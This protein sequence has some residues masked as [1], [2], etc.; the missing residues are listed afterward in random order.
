MKTERFDKKVMS[1]LQQEFTKFG[2]EIAKKF[3]LGIMANNGSYDERQA[4]FCLKFFTKRKLTQPI[5]ERR[6]V[7]QLLE[8]PRIGERFYSPKLKEEFEIVGYNKDDIN[9]PIIC[10]GL[11]TK[12]KLAFPALIK[13]RIGTKPPKRKVKHV[14]E[15]VVNTKPRK[16]VVDSSWQ[17]LVHKGL[18]MK[19]VYIGQIMSHGKPYSKYKTEQGKFIHQIVR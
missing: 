1:Q 11:K 4:N 5:T 12:K 13:N 16:V 17:E 7:A 8:Y 2:S 3:G 9:F 6:R 19:V 15:E 14:V 18:K 10:R